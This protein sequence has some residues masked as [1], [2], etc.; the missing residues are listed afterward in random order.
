MSTNVITTGPAPLG[1]GR[2]AV[3]RLHSWLQRHAAYL[4]WLAICGWGATI[5]Q[6]VM[7]HR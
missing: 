3:V 4:A 7:W 2:R 5:A 1:R 6:A